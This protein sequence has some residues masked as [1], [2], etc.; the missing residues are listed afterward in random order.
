[1]ASRRELPPVNIEKNYWK[2]GLT[3]AAIDEAGRGP[4][5][6]E[7]VVGAVV[8]DPANIPVAYDSKVLTGSAREKL[9][10][11]VRKNAYAYGVGSAS[12]QEI[13]S[14]GMS[15]ALALAAVRALEQLTV[16]FD[17]LLIDGPHNITKA[18][19]RT[20]CV[21]KGETHSRSI[22]AA[23]LLAKTAHDRLILEHALAFPGYGLERNMGYGTPEHLK[24]LRALGPTAQHRRSFKPVREAL[25]TCSGDS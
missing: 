22:A 2:K 13:D 17:V 20:H 7:V 18:S 21:V 9:A 8:L 24:A 6:G 5:F 14:L 3:V 4:L 12:A 11:D 23:S 1:M 10:I 25:G 15:A 19:Y 16:E